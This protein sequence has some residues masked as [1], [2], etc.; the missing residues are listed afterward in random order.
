MIA[1]H[2][3]HHVLS[4]FA[5]GAAPEEIKV[6]YERA[7]AYQQPARPV[8]EDFVKRLSDKNEFKVLA[9]KREQYPNF[10]EFFQREI[11]AKGVEDVVNEYVFKG[12]EF[13]DDMLARTFGG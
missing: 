9:G 10:L 12:D 1:D 8:N 6:A 4:I 2:T 7:A 3:A 13:A 11:E 5:L